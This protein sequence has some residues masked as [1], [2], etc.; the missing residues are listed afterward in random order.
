MD[1]IKTFARI[2]DISENSCREC[3]KETLRL[4]SK[5]NLSITREL[6]SID[7]V[8]AIHVWSLY[9]I[10]LALYNSFQCVHKSVD[11]LLDK[12]FE[13]IKDD[14]SHE[15]RF[16]YVWMLTALYHDA[17]YTHECSMKIVW[18]ELQ[19]YLHYS[20]PCQ[21]KYV[22][23]IFSNELICSY[24]WFRYIH[25]GKFDH[26][27]WGGL[28]FYRSIHEKKELPKEAIFVENVYQC[29]AWT[30]VCHNI[31]YATKREDHDIYKRFGLAQLCRENSARDITLSE[32]P[33]LYLLSMAD[34]I[35]PYKRIEKTSCFE[36]IA[37]KPVNSIL[38]V[39]IKETLNFDNDYIKYLSGLSSMKDWLT[40]VELE[41]K[42]KIIIRIE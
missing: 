17:G 21:G 28:Q 35:E 27:I 4:F 14:V 10:G 12:L 34:N 26:G 32:H 42:N 18:D 23:E 38:V 37:L 30:I 8:R 31:W 16:K 39:D 20:L 2:E 25:S 7:K 15:D 33:L 13:K 9:K 11:V 22:P 24:A 40:D 5:N 29:V 1:S 36:D 19:D 41:G 6:D 3:I